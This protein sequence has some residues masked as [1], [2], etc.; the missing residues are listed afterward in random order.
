MIYATDNGA[1]VINMSLGASSYSRGEE[2]AVDYA[3]SHGVVVVGCRG[4]HRQR[5]LS[6]T[7]PRIPNAIA[8]AA[9]DADDTLSRVLHP[10][11]LVVDVAAPG[12]S[13]SIP[14][15]PNNRYGYLSGTS[16]ATPHVA[17]LAALILSLQPD[18]DTRTR[19]AASS[20]QRR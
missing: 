7:P 4:Q 6:I 18:P 12:C 16:M 15:V 11:R 3:W 10:R 17:G 5:R 2:M 9:T 19:C 20:K 14:R 1:R 8:V 13:A